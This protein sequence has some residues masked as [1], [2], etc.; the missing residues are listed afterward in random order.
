MLKLI[1]DDYRGRFWAALKASF[2]TM[3]LYFCWIYVYIGFMSHADFII[4]SMGIIPML[5]GLFLSRMYPNQLHK[6]LFLCPLSE[7]DRKRYIVTAYRVRV[8]ISM[9]LYLMF[10]LPAVLSGYISIMKGAAI[11]FL[12]LIFVL[13]VNMHHSFLSVQIAR[14]EDDPYYWPA[15]I[16]GVLSAFSQITGCFAM[17]DFARK[18]SLEETFQIELAVMIVMELLLN[19]GICLI[20]YKPVMEYGVSYEKCHFIDQKFYRPKRSSL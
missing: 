8:G 17:M 16:Y 18:R 14:T 7:Q 5:L 9:I 12:V 4:Y 2:N 1:L 19:A 6:L 20:C 15:F 11:G 3:T 10:S 13:G